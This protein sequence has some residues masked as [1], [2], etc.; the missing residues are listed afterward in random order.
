MANGRIRPLY[1]F[2]DG[3]PELH[4]E[5]VYSLRYRSSGR[6]VDESVGKDAQFALIAKVQR[7]HVLRCQTLGLAEPVTA[8]PKGSSTRDR[9][10]PK[11]L[12]TKIAAY[13]AEIELR[14]AHRAVT[15]YKRALMLFQQ[16]C[17]KTRLA[18]MDRTDVLG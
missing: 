5:R 4:P 1:V 12:A 16:T 11:Q 13:L 7:E 15:S 9:S 14:S 18:E 17:L 3:K 6:R 8:E 10:E 2:L